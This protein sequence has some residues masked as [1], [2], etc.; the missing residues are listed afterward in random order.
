M[1]IIAY[2]RKWANHPR[3][4]TKDNFG[5]TEMKDSGENKTIDSRLG[6]LPFAHRRRVAVF[7]GSFD[8]IHLGHVNI[9]KYLLETRILLENTD[10][11]REGNVSVAE[12]I[13]DTPEVKKRF[14]RRME[15]YKSQQYAMKNGQTYLHEIEKPLRPLGETAIEEVIFVPALCSPFKEG[16]GANSAQRLEM[17]KRVC[18]NNP[19]FSYTDIELRRNGKSYS[20]DTME[21]LTKVLGELDLHF[22]IGMDSLEGLSRWYRAQEFVQRFNFIIY[23]RPGVQKPSFISLENFFGTRLARKLIDSMLDEEGLPESEISS[24][25]VRQRLAQGQDASDLLPPEVLEYIAENK[26]YSN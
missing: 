8:P 19:G 7:G 9:A 10:N 26:L 20:I 14:E 3:Q 17:L 21:T 4:E 12:L 25:E 5:K 1:Y 6:N 24:T 23:P 18:L 16:T 13:R 2:S 22:V 11:S 15:K